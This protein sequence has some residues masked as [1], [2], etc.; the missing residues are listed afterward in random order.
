LTQNACGTGIVPGKVTTQ[1]G[2]STS[3]QDVTYIQKE[4]ESLTQ[5]RTDL[6]VSASASFSAFAGG[7]SLRATYC[8]STALTRYSFFLMVH[9]IVLNDTET[10]EQT[11]L[12]GNARSVADSNESPPIFE[13][14]GTGKM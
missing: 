10:Y 1:A 8:N 4:I 11:A 13:A 7:G 9:V 12:D 6:E 5:L 2:S 3:G 14:R